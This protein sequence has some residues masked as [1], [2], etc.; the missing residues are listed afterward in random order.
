L[1]NEEQ[2]MTCRE[3]V[4]FLDDYVAGALPPARRSLFDAHVAACPDCRN[5]L[6]SYREAVRLGRAAFSEDEGPVPQEVP[7]DLVKAILAAR[8]AAPDA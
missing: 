3:L 5:Y 4:R 1:V 6:D 7:V 2:Q 8:P